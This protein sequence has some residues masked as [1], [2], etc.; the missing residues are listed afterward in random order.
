M[1]VINIDSLTPEEA[2]AQAE[3]KKEI[4]ETVGRYGAAGNYLTRDGKPWFPV[5]GEFHFSRFRPE[6]WR[7]AVAKMKAGGVRILAT[8]V[9]WIYHEERQ[10]EWDFSG[11]RDLRRF[12]EVCKEED[13]PVFLRIGP[14]AHGECRNGGFPDWLMKKKDMTLRSDDPGYLQLVENFWKKVYEQVTGYL[15]SQG[16]TVIGTQIENEYGHCGGLQGEK[17]MQHMRTLKALA[18]KTGFI[19]PYYTATGWGGGIVPKGCLPVLAAY[20]GAPWEQHTDPLPLNANFVFSHCKDDKNVGSDLR[21]GEESGF[22]YDTEKFPYLMAEL[23]GGLQVTGH[24]RPYVEGR[25][26]AAMAVCKAGSGAALLG[27]Y[28]Y[29]GGT[30]PMG[31]DSSMQE[32]IETGYSNNL[33]VRSYDFQAPIGEYGAVGESYYMLRPLH[34]FLEEFGD[35]MAAGETILPKFNSEDPAKMEE[36]RVSL[37]HIRGTGQ[38][39][40]FYNRYQRH[41]KMR[42]I[43]ASYTVREGERKIQTPDILMQKNCWGWIPY[44]AEETDGMCLT[45]AFRLYSSNYAPLC[46]LK[47]DVVFFGEGEPEIVWNGGGDAIC[48]DRWSAEHA[49]K[50]GEKLYVADG[51]LMVEDNQLYL[52]TNQEEN[53]VVIYPEEKKADVSCEKAKAELKITQVKNKG[54]ENGE[55]YAEYELSITGDLKECNDVWIDLDICGDRGIYWT[56]DGAH[57][58]SRPDGDWFYQGK[59]WKISW[60]YIG[61]PEKICVRIYQAKS[62][63][64]VYY[65]KL[66]KGNTG[67]VQADV[68]TEYK[69]PVTIE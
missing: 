43:K 38:G 1:Q 20:C 10:G 21:I 65:E 63:K 62:G 26:T 42:T 28:M 45:P 30:N 46:R 25:D 8:Y 51:C 5:M 36:S 68:R 4:M 37:R 22:T 44:A 6:Y 31:K 69:I 54:E 47:E 39:F 57:D 15:Y 41:G 16:G 18:E 67:I 50:Y 2:S 24:R 55:L 58:A 13:M 19:T 32:S 48:I 11:A 66:P 35:L 59:T 49:I 14:W 29:H 23:G 12:L 9:F 7:E 33:P 56:G 34:M 60:R 64:E 53:Q 61:C 27:Y 52:L 40:L 17:G 3:K